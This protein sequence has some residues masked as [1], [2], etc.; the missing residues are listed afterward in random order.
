MAT[1]FGHTFQMIN[2]ARQ[3][4]LPRYFGPTWEHLATFSRGMRE[5][6]CFLD[7]TTGQSYIEIVNR[8][9][10]DVNSLFLHIDDENEW[11][12]CYMWL[13]EQK[14]LRLKLGEEF[15]IAR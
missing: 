8:Q 12:D 11:N 10:S 7:T 14:I 15:Y 1:Q 5:Y 2:P 6:M 9:A 13:I 3:P 4:L